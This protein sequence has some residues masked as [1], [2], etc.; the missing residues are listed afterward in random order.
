MPQWFLVILHTLVAILVL[1]VITKLLGKRQ[2]SQLSLF[3]YITGITIGSLAAYIPL[4]SRETWYLGVI[5]L[6]V[7]TVVS[8]VIEYFQIKSKK[9]RDLVDGTGRVL[10]KNGKVL[11]DNLRKERVSMDE[12]M[13]QL[14][15]KGAFKVADVEF[16]V[17]ENSGEINFLLTKENQPLTPKMLGLDVSPEKEPQSVVVDGQ[18]QE[19]ELAEAHRDQRWLHSELG[20]HGVELSNV[21]LAQVESNGRMHLD[22]YEDQLQAD[23][24]TDLNPLLAALETCQ[25]EFK[26]QAANAQGK[27]SKQ[28]YETGYAQLTKL[29]LDTQKQLKS[30]K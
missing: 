12:L 2:V 28:L 1:F 26:K 25:E 22:L 16:A 5:S 18:I 27:R 4:E 8:L 10:I 14:R 3:E 7:W 11:E 6:V 15:S 19:K 9:I 23:Q 13:S 29:V 17:M 21:F 24:P 20:K 30:K